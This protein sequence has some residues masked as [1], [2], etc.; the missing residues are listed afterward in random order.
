MNSGGNGD[1]RTTEE[2]MVEWLV[3]NVQMVVEWLM[4]ETGFTG[5]GGGVRRPSAGCR[6]WWCMSETPPEKD[7]SEFQ[8]G[9]IVICCFCPRLFHLFWWNKKS[10][11]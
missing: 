9:K 3:E 6:W 5:G 10:V 11:F 2:A 1:G 7:A 4:D 8:E